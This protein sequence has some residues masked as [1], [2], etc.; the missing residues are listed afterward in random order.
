M[1]A[2][3]L[4]RQAREAAGLSVRELGRRAGTSHAAVLAYEAG[5]REPRVSTLERLLAA[6]GQRPRVVLE[7]RP[8]LDVDEAGRRLA[9]V[10]ELADALPKRAASKHLD[11]PVLGR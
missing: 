1:D 4:V 5:R 2:A 8:P 3:L 7:A 11:Y 6:A 10:L 9:Q